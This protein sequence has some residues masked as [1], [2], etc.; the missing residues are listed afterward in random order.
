MVRKFRLI[1]EES[2]REH[3]I[4]S[5]TFSE[6]YEHGLEEGI[7]KTRAEVEVMVASEILLR[8]GRKKWGEPHARVLNQVETI[9]DFGR[10]ELLLDRVLDTSSW[11]ELFPP[12]ESSV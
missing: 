5:K 9:N 3:F 1:D 12:A 10:L 6:G 2:G 8:L 7:A 11:D 4:W